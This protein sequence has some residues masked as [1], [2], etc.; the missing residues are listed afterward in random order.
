MFVV[1]GK[2]LNLAK[3]EKIKAEK[4]NNI[5]FLQSKSNKIEYNIISTK[6]HKNIT[7]EKNA[8]YL[9]KIEQDY[10]CI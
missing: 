7:S 1:W 2:L 10:I 6:S 4:I 9:W 5:E 8:K 3:F